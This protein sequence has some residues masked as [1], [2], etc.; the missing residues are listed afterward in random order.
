MNDFIS[1]I[2]QTKDRLRIKATKYIDSSIFVPNIYGFR[3]T[4][5]NVNII[6]ECQGNEKINELRTGIKVTK[7]KLYILDSDAESF[8]LV[9]ECRG[10]DYEE[11]FKHLFNNIIKLMH[12]GYKTE[13]SIKI[14]I[15][16]WYNFLDEETKNFSFEE[17]VGLSGELYF[18]NQILQNG[19]L[20]IIDSW[21]GPIGAEK[22]FVI[23]SKVFFE[24][25]SSCKNTKHIHRISDSNQ[26]APSGGKVYLVSLAFK[27]LQQADIKSFDIYTLIEKITFLLK[28]NMYSYN[29]FLNK[30][31]EIRFNP[32]SKIE[33]PLLRLEDSLIIL[34]QESNYKNF[35]T[36]I[37]NN[38]ILKVIY[39]YDFNGLKTENWGCIYDEL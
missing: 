32:N 13:N 24:I 29:I 16:N 12:S 38:R 33:V 34:I 17:L 20:S 30:L 37:D 6:F 26:L 35:V 36:N 7:Q 14:S 2:E 1:S 3:D 27:K 31:K 8:F 28:D 10:A 4:N 9:C 23:N 15:S 21:Y 5:N 22:D 25:K 39:D 18:I 11:D 19:H